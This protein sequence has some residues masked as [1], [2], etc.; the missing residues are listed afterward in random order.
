VVP[1]NPSSNA[2]TASSRPAPG[3][4]PSDGVSLSCLPLA[5]PM[6]QLRALW[7][8]ASHLPP[9]PAMPCQTS[10]A[11]Q[12][13][14]MTFVATCT[15]RMLTR[16]MQVKGKSQIDGIVKRIQRL[17]PPSR[18]R[19]QAR[20]DRPRITTLAYIFHMTTG[21]DSFQL[22]YS[23]RIIILALSIFSTAFWRLYLWSQW[24]GNFRI[25]F[26]FPG[27]ILITR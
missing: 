27:V 16:C 9:P 10:D 12:A 26:P 23:L 19:V 1:I 25:V 3:A 17:G 18:S 15:I 21:Y 13:S 6:R 2:R 14:W 22:P 24:V 8:F 11:S 20:L 7:T 5:F 4:R